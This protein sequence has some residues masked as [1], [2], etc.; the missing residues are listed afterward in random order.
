M[1]GND[2]L[3]LAVPCSLRLIR[4]QAHGRHPTVKGACELF[5]QDGCVVFAA[6]LPGHGASPGLRGHLPFTAGSLVDM[7]IRIADYAVSHSL[8]HYF[9]NKEGS[10]EEMPRVVLVGSSMGGA[11]A[12]ASA[13]LI[14]S[15]ERVSWKDRLAG[16][17]LLTPM[18]QLRV[19]TV[20]RWV[21]SGLASLVPTWKM[22]P[23]HCSSMESQYRDPH[24]RRQCELDKY[25]YMSDWFRVGSASTCVELTH[26]VQSMLR[27]VSVPFLVLVADHDVSVDV[28]GSLDLMDLSA[29]NDKQLRRYDALHGILCEPP[30]RLDRIHSDMLDWIRKRT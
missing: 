5:A 18:L 11:I 10:R 22:I 4:S 27:Q 23:S 20:E 24:K 2:R 29:S 25:R 3:T 16:V 13:Q 26:A 17:I 12:L 21:L 30:H 19:S 6:D 15:R 14:A 8:Q 7:G 9:G 1:R 28:Q